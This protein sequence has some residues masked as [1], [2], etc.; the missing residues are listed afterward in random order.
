M[1]IRIRR[2]RR[3]DFD[4]LAALLDRGDVSPR[5]KR[6][7][8]NVVADLAYDL[9]VAEAEGALAGVVGVSYVRSLSLGGQRATL[10]E[11]FVAPSRRGARV[12]ARLLAFAT[13]RVRT[14]GARAFVACPADRDGERFLEHAGFV[15]R[16]SRLVRDLE[17]MTP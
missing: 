9:Y 2:A 12:G 10:E 13:D 16:G 11:L 7:F 17:G 5:A 4:A 6:M 14:R 3:T 15:A 1:E 8:R